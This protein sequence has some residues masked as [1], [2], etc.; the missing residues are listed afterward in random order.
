[1][2]GLAIGVRTVSPTSADGYCAVRQ[3]VWWP[4]GLGDGRSNV[5]DDGVQTLLGDCHRHG[6][7]RAGAQTARRRSG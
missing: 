1:M 3:T 7:I 2:V 6:D 5:D 4:K